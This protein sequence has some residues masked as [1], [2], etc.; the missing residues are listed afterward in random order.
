MNNDSDGLDLV[1]VPSGIA[2]LDTI[3]GGGFFKG[4]VY[5]VQG[6]PGTGKTIL[7]NQVCFAH[8]R[9]GGRAAYITLLAESHTRM[10]QHLRPLAFFDENAIPE[11]LYYISAFRTLEEEGLKGLLDVLRREIGG[12]HVSC[13]ILDG[14]VAAEEAASSDRELKKF[15]HELQSYASLVGCTV[16]LL[17]SGPTHSRTVRAEHTMVDGLIELDETLYGVRTERSLQV[18]KFRG[19]GSLRGRH[20][21]RIVSDGIQ[22]L[23]RIEAMFAQPSALQPVDR[24]RVTSGM[25]ALDRMIR[26]GLPSASTIMVVGASGTGKTTFG[27]QFVGRA[28]EAEPGLFFGFYETPERLR[29]TARFVGIDLAGL[30]S[31]GALE[32]HW[33]PQGENVLDELGHALLD[34]VR[35][36][37]VRRLFI[38]SLDAFIESAVAPER[39]GR[40][41]AVLANELRARGVTTVFSAETRETGGHYGL[42]PIGG[43]SALADGLL[44]LQVVRADRGPLQRLMSVTKLRD[45]AFDSVPQR[46]S[47]DA[48][49][50]T[51]HGPLTGEDVRPAEVPS[52]ALPG[53]SLS[54][55]PPAEGAQAR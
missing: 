26:G 2:G 9:T 20:F 1:R 24:P 18:R 25:D 40:F 33:R 48:A 51:L 12:R 11:Q 3:L 39:I 31:K 44:Y 41:F 4:G 5:I 34:A 6:V 28:S 42:V 54:S 38:D 19:A 15:I 53:G 13:L 36:R 23:P 29:D 21:F 50:L 7:A 52:A 55:A 27:L 37:K 22:V 14:M 10:M 47:I 30:E 32:I 35:R 16:F 46:F 45:T 17:T 49:G 8:V 43:I